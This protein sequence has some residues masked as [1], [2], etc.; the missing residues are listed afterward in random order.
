ML[1]EFQRE[2]IIKNFKDGRVKLAETLNCSYSDVAYF[3]KYRLM[4]DKDAKQYFR[5]KI[6][7]MLEQGLSNK[8]IAE[9]LELS[10]N[11]VANTLQRCEKVRSPRKKKETYSSSGRKNS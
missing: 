9:N 4:R 10:L 2:Y 6:N 1:N 3:F 8:Q 7:E 5:Y 11:V